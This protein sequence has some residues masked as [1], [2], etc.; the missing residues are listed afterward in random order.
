MA[1]LQRMRPRDRGVIMQVGSALGYR[2]IPL[3]A[4]YCG[5]KH[6]LNGFIESL[7]TEL[8][9]CGSNVFVGIVQMPGVN[10]PQFDHCRSKMDEHPQPVAPIYQPEV[11]ADALH[12][13]VRHRR[14]ELWVGTPTVYTILGN[15][16][17]SAVMDWY[18][19]RS[20]VKGQLE[21]APPTSANKQGNLFDASPGDPGAHGSFDGKAHYHSVQ[22]LPAR[23][24]TAAAA[25]AAGLAAAATLG[26]RVRR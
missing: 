21:Q 2:G 12:W 3:Q 16:V 17:S 6:A 20:G 10:T 5:A 19:A 9:Q 18:L 24:R 15:R 23:H 7:R 11:A 25:I 14:R 22:Q 1:A 8:R 4:P 26:L 13:A